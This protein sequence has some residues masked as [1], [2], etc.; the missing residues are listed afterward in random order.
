M[1]YDRKGFAFCDA[2]AVRA[3]RY[4][5][6]LTVIVREVSPEHRGDYTC[7]CGEPANWYLFQPRDGATV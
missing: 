7:E 5:S 3:L 6:N 2:H 4:L 1:S